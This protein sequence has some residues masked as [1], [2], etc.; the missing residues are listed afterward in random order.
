MQTERPDLRLNYIVEGLIVQGASVQYE[1]V[2]GDALG[3]VIHVF[4]PNVP[5]TAMITYPVSEADASNDDKR[6]G[7]RQGLDSRWRR[8]FMD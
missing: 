4:D 7:L 6:L 5:T 8:A 2:E 1:T 3:W